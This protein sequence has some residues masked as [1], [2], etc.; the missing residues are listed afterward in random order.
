MVLV[1]GG[2]VICTNVLKA[3]WRAW[4]DMEREFAR[5]EDEYMMQGK[6]GLRGQC[7]LAY[8]VPVRERRQPTGRW[9]QLLTL[10]VLDYL[11]VA[12]CSQSWSNRCSCRLERHGDLAV[13]GHV[14]KGTCSEIP[15][16]AWGSF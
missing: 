6:L 2:L 12:C 7:Q 5:W 9:L 4:L 8:T 11:P 1:G 15:K 14:Y 16:D 13:A 3:T 10:D